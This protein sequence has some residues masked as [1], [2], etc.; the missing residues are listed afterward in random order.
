MFHRRDF[1]Y[2]LG[3]TL[4][5]AALNSLLHAES[6]A[7]ESA[8]PLAQKST[9]HTPRANSCIFLFMEGGPSHIDT[10]DPKPKLRDLHMQEFERKDKFASAMAS[11]KRY[12]VQSPFEFRQAGKSGLWMNALFEQL[13]GVADDLCVYK[14]CVAESINHPTACFHMNTGSRFGGEPAV[15]SWVTYGLGSVNQNLPG[16]VVLPEAYYPQG[17]SANWSNGYLPAHYQGTSLRPSGSP[18]LDLNPPA[19]VTRQQQ[20]ANLDLLAQLERGHQERHPQHDEL[21]ARLHSYELAYRMQAQVPELIDLSRESEKTLAA[22][23]I[24]QEE[25]DAFGR[26]CLLAR[27]LIENGVRFVQVFSG[28][29][30]SHDYIEKAHSA[31]IRTVDKPMAALI[32]DLKQRGMLDNTLVIWAGEFGRSPDNGMR[33]GIKAGRDHTAK[34]MNIVLAGGGVRGGQVAGATDDIGGKAVEVSHPIKDLHVTLLHL[35]G[36][37]DNKLTY[38][39]GGRFKQLSQTG[40]EVIRELLA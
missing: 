40:G 9:H 30:D 20:R 8:D 33:G 34:A 23:G 6:P 21:A 3:A 4:G 28:G 17:G 38:F 27:R 29:W 39:H 14:G 26:K 5:T 31:R 35:L 24:G 12:Y 16:F 1:L 2:G 36:L 37:N 22:Y 15:G 13:A 32:A 10:F 7:A 19:G 18:I 25:T 11:G